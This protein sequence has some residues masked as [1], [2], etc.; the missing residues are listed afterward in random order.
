MCIQAVA[1]GEATNSLGFSK[2][3]NRDFQA[4]LSASLDNAGLLATLG[5]C[6]FPLEVN[7]LSL[8][9]AGSGLDVEVTSHVIYRVFDTA[10]Q[11]ISLEIIS[12][13]FTSTFADSPGGSKRLRKANEGSIRANILQF[14]HK[15]V[16]TRPRLS[17]TDGSLT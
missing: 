11:P 9:Q 3:G 2:V 16:A 10:G 1:G 14:F 7:L 17:K 6:K 4:A 5:A 12:A 8:S 15:V 13:P